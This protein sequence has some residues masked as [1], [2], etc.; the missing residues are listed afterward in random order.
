MT[1]VRHR[2]RGKRS[3]LLVCRFKTADDARTLPNLK[4]VA[5]NQLLGDYLRRPH[6]VIAAIQFVDSIF[7][8]VALPLSGASTTELS[9]TDA[10]LGPLSV[11]E[12]I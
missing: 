4:V 7:R 6:D 8:P 12:V 2:E 10:W 3:R 9:A 5:I 11:M 1:G